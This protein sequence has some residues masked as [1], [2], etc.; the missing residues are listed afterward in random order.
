MVAKMGLVGPLSI[1]SRAWGCATAVNYI[2]LSV[3]YRVR[4]AQWQLWQDVVLSQH[5]LV[6]SKQA[7][8]ASMCEHTCK[9]HEAL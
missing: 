2:C 4:L 8:A 5:L 1:L 7:S 9:A 3:E 6:E